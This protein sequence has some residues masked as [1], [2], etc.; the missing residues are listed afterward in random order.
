MITVWQHF[1]IIQEK[2]LT[3]FERK[4]VS[5]FSLS[6]FRVYIIAEI[7]IEDWL[8][9][10]GG[11]AESSGQTC[12]KWVWWILKELFRNIKLTCQ[13]SCVEEYKQVLAWYTRSAAKQ[14]K[15][16]CVGDWKGAES[17]I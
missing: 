2:G 13:M 14:T 6:A 12:L 16:S 15:Q 4:S 5:F 10:V 11:Y 7:R 3:D 17:H 1:K 8:A 9:G